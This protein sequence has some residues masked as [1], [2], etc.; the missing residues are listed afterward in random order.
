MKVVNYRTV[1]LFFKSQP[2]S[3]TSQFAANTMQVLFGLRGSDGEPLVRFYCAD[4]Q[5]M[6]GMCTCPRLI[7]PLRPTTAIRYRALNDVSVAHG[8]LMDRADLLKLTGEQ[9]EAIEAHSMTRQR[10]VDFVTWLQDNLSGD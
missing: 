5:E 2:G 9:I 7:L 3:A 4:Y 6:P 1:Y 10:V 8:W